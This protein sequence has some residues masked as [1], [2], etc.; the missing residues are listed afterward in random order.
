MSVVV[1]LPFRL[2]AY[3]ASLALLFGMTG[4][5]SSCSKEPNA[6]PTPSVLPVQARSVINGDFIFSQSPVATMDILK[7]EWD[8]ELFPYE[9]LN[10]PELEST[11]KL[12]FW[13][14]G[15]LILISRHKLCDFQYPGGSSGNGY[16]EYTIPPFL[17][18]TL[19]VKVSTETPGKSLKSTSYHPAVTSLE[20]NIDVTDNRPIVFAPTSATINSNIGFL[21]ASAIAVQWNHYE[22]G[23]P[24]F[25][26]G[27]IVRAFLT[28]D[29]PGVTYEIFADRQGNTGFEN[30]GSEILRLDA[31]TNGTYDV[32]AGSY[33]LALDNQG[34]YPGIAFRPSYVLVS[35][36]DVR[37]T[38]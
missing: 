22:L 32:P 38:H 25:S 26:S 20:G 29:Y 30:D 16:L 28:N 17:S 13:K 10:H 33:S 34:V 15:K 31:V 5:L 7:I 8:S 14:N 18:G 21:N 9:V 1:K 19:H 12:E 24:Q 2:G 36:P 23:N 27:Y 37:V 35:G 4:L 6:E 3:S 11:V